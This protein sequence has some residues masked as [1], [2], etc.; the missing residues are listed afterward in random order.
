MVK[1]K[2]PKLTVEDHLNNTPQCIVKLFDALKIRILELGINN[3][4]EKVTNPYIGYKFIG[5]KN[6]RSKLFVEVHLQ[7]K[8]IEL[9]LRPLE[10]DDMR[11]TKAPD[12]HR[13]TLNK[14]VDI[15]NEADLNY[16]MKFVEQSYKDFL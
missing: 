7:Q 14:L 4:Q 10:Y 15:N 8:K 5:N 2:L 12:T 13:W 3:I 6:K 1:Q 16:I 9:H 11:V